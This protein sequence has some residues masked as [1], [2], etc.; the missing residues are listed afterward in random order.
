MCIRDSQGSV[1]HLEF[2]SDQEKSVFKTFSEISPKDIIDLAVDR[3][4]YIDMSQSLNLVLR[5]NYSMKDIYEIHKY[6]YLGGTLEDNPGY[7]IKTLYYCYSDSH[8]S[9]G[10]DGD[11]WDTCAACAD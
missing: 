1:Q 7:G 9:L 3:Q 4:K 8:A 6:A 2:L 10:V 5:Q 11:S